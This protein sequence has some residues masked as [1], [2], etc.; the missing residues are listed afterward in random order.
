[1]KPSEFE[2]HI[3][4]LEREDMHYL[5]QNW[6]ASA[7]WIFQH[8]AAGADIAAALPA[9]VAVYLEA[10][11]IGVL[12]AAAAAVAVHDLRTG[13]VARLR[14][15]LE[16]S[17]YR[18]WIFEGIGDAVGKGLK[19]APAIPLLLEFCGA[20][21]YLVIQLLLRH[22]GKRG[23]AEAAREVAKGA[24]GELADFLKE[25]QSKKIAIEPALP[26]LA[27]Q[28]A[29]GKRARNAATTFRWL[30]EL[31]AD[32]SGVAGTLEAYLDAKEEDIAAEAG[33]C[34]ACHHAAKREWP[35]VDA[36]LAAKHPRAAWAA[37]RALRVRLLGS[38]DDVAGIV[39]RV[40]AGLLS[41]DSDTAARSLVTLREAKEKGRRCA[42]SRELASRLAAS[43]DDR[44][45]EYLHL[46]L[47]PAEL[48]ALRPASNRLAAACE[49]P[50]EACAI[51]ARLPRAGNWSHDSDLPKE[52]A[53]LTGSGGSARCPECGR[54]YGRSYSEEW[55]DMSHSE[56]WS[57]E[58][59]TPPEVLAGVKGA[60]HEEYEKSLGGW[61][62]RF[63]EELRHP[64]LAVREEAAYDL[65]AHFEARGLWN[66]LAE[67]ITSSEDAVR[68]RVLESI[69]I[70]PEDPAPIVGTLR[71]LFD[72]HH[73]TVRSRAA[74]IVATRS[75]RLND[76][77]ALRELLDSPNEEFLAAASE[78]IFQGTHRAFDT[79]PFFER[80]AT[81]RNHPAKGISGPARRALTLLAA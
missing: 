68:I 27:A 45:A 64:A 74:E 43:L 19:L 5:Q 34:L 72:S 79:A 7:R 25:A 65:A 41:A 71:G 35:A 66:E 4:V 20:R 22:A 78:A 12:R 69:R 62:E 21:Q 53:K 39:D 58:R 10:T 76:V 18:D 8:G 63:R 51:C 23:F 17:Q 3:G 30:V 67:L 46:A 75:V 33:Y 70:R 15:L 1:M 29:D 56:S 77:A 11:Q 47:P 26:E 28:L 6:E 42:P 55:D 61:I 49:R 54:Y 48:G 13:D 24:P 59:W 57:L 80:F 9:L 2:Q 44:V 36:L 50:V 16:K 73:S 52:Y 32:L 60:A 40:A 31:G 81:L 38:G 37:A 14:E